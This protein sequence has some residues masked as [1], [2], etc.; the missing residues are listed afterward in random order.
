MTNKLFVLPFLE[1][2]V[3]LGERDR[4]GIERIPIRGSYSG[5]DRSQALQLDTTHKIISVMSEGLGYVLDG[6]GATTPLQYAAGPCRGMVEIKDGLASGEGYCVRTNPN[7]GKWLL[8]W[9]I[10][11]AS[12]D[13]LVGRWD[14]TGIAGDAKGWK[15]NGTWGPM[16]ITAPGRFV[17]HLVGHLEPS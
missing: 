1:S 14:I 7:G 12:G 13:G 9:R 4:T 15:G 16:V 10:T 11:A 6:R 5:V 2:M 8:K 3:A 17:N